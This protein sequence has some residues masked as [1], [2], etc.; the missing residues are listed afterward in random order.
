MTTEAMGGEMGVWS[1]IA[2]AEFLRRPSRPADHESENRALVALA[3][4]MSSSPEGILQRLAE[5]ALALCSAD[6]AGITLLETGDDG[7]P[8]LR[9]HGVAGCFAPR[10]WQL[11]P[12]DFSPCGIV[13]DVG[14]PQ[15][16]HLPERYFSYLAEVD[17]RIVEALLIPFSVAGELVGTVWALSH[18]EEHRFD[19][20][21]LRV[22]VNLSKLAGVAYQVQSSV[23]DLQEADRRKDEF[24]AV[25]AHE[26]RNPLAPIVNAGQILLREDA[27]EEERRA[28]RE[29]IDRQVRQM[30]RLVDDLMDVSRISHGRIE[31]RKRTVDVAEVARRA[32]ETS[33]PLIAARGHH[34][35]VTLPSEPLLAEA[36]PTRLEQ[37]F[38]N[39]L[40]NAAKYTEPGGRIH[41][42]A[43]RV[44]GHAV[45]RVRDSGIGISPEQLSGLFEMFAQGDRSL[46]RAQGGLGIGLGLARSLVEM[47]GGTVRADS[48]G[49]G[50][51][52]EFTV[53][54]PLLAAAPEAAGPPATA[55]SPASGLSGG[56][57]VLVV[58]DNQDSADS[59]ALLLQIRGY[60]VR[61][62]YDGLEA[63]TAAAEF[64]PS[65]VLL[66]IG[67]PKMN[68][69][70]AARRIRQQ[71]GGKD[72]KLVALTGWGQEEDKRRALA[73]GFDL[74][75][76][77]PLEPALLEQLLASAV[78]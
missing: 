8:I 67:L 49:P 19:G 41:L 60:E 65:M 50:R 64:A 47:H 70:E 9:W 73:A 29:V 15:F 25:L 54:L 16:F 2:T 76:T 37:V 34:L 78:A 62:A 58:D 71:P 75:V 61:T 12:R 21:D 63:V 39:L 11:M 5:V 68:G 43:E 23:R 27:A 45:I 46:E 10:L 44:D 35:D 1:V 3:Q 36:D 42:A 4:E 6:S 55:A 14:S 77:K 38:S 31:L 56:L 24:L 48:A 40:N 7:K 69:Y 30:A 18:D 59:M 52:S 28:A 32:I 26:L 51:G 33:R 20:E 13:L 72:L 22:M 66:D 53:R 57:R 74:H 17:P